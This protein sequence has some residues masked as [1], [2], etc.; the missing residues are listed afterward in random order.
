M[1]RRY[2]QMENVMAY[3]R[4]VSTADNYLH[5]IMYRRAINEAGNAR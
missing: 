3:A 5:H 2:R 4:I 1:A